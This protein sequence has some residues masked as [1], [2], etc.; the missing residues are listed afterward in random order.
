[1][2]VRPDG[3]SDVEASLT[4]ST[5]VPSARAAT[6]S[7][8]SRLVERVSREWTWVVYAAAVGVPGTVTAEARRG[9]EEAAASR[10]AAEVFMVANGVKEKGR[11]V[12]VNVERM[13]GRGGA[14]FG[15]EKRGTGQGMPGRRAEVLMRVIE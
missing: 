8:T 10:M 3:W 1:M 11:G 6:T 14:G 2:A 13:G 4:S 15:G 7:S 5:D 9:K 12:D